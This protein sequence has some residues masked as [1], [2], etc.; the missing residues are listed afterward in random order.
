[1]IFISSALRFRLRKFSSIESVN[2]CNSSSLE[3]LTRN[4][5]AIERWSK[6]RWRRIEGKGNFAHSFHVGKDVSH[7]FDLVEKS[8]LSLRQEFLWSKKDSFS[9]WTQINDQYSVQSSEHLYHE[10]HFP[11]IQWTMTHW[12][13]EEDQLLIDVVQRDGSDANQWSFIFSSFVIDQIR[14][15]CSRRNVQPS[16]VFIIICPSRIVV[17]T[18]SSV[19]NGFLHNLW[20]IDWSWGWHSVEEKWWSFSR[21]WTWLEYVH[22]SFSMEK[23]WSRISTRPDANRRRPSTHSISSNDFFCSID[24]FLPCSLVFFF[25]KKFLCFLNEKSLEPTD[26]SIDQ[27]ALSCTWC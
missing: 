3:L 9:S 23:Y 26:S 8:L 1:M 22:H 7:H 2:Q 15:V 6:D 11:S 13:S 4:S 27:L 10:V 19:E 14:S 5:S 18:K 25:C 12:S 16:C 21:F 24:P 20:C 17:S